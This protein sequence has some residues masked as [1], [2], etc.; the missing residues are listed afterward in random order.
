M[1]DVHE[2]V[3]REVDE[4]AAE[5]LESAEEI[6]LLRELADRLRIAEIEILFPTGYTDS[7]GDGTIDSIE[8]FIT[9][10]DAD[11]DAI[12]YPGTMDISLE[13]HATFAKKARIVK[14]WEASR[15][16]LAEAWHEGLF[17]SYALLLEWDEAPSEDEAL[18]LRVV[19]HPLAGES[20]E[21]WFSMTGKFS[22]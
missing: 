15:K 13:T 11:G 3:Q 9:P 10:R 2:L 18:L 12:K 22:K 5:N 21:E 7:S 17:P 14:S 1:L 19:F 16:T 8:A 4:T 6:R 20:L